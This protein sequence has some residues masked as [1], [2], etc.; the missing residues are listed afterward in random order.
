MTASVELA[1]KVWE[2]ENDYRTHHALGPRHREL[3]ATDNLEQTL[4]LLKRNFIITLGNRTCYY[5][6][7]FTKDWYKDKESMNLIADLQKIDQVME[8]MPYAKA[9]RIAVLFSESLVAQYTSRF[10]NGI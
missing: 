5:F 8:K 1:G 10:D 4:E 2:A 9:N 7:D 3:G 6:F